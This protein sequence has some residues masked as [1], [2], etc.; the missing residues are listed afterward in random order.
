M[1]TCSPPGSRSRPPSRRP[2]LGARTTLPRPAEGLPDQP[3]QTRWPPRP[4]H[5]RHVDQAVPGRHHPG[6]PRGGHRQLIH[7]PGSGPKPR[8]PDRLQP[9]RRAAH[10]GRHRARDQERRAGPPV[11]R[12]APA[13][14]PAI[15]V[16]NADMER[17]QMR[18]EADVSLRPRGE[19]VSAPVSRSRHELVPGGR[20]GDRPRG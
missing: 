15:G 14:A 1:S 17:G 5:V 3:V 10:G 19:E 9:L 6:A 12:E 2:R 13:P 4:T 18:V 8:S 20:T 7:D 11:R 16:S